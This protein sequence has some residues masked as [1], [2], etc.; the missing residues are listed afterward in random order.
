[1]KKI[2]VF[3]DS[4]SYPLPQS[5]LNVVAEADMTVFC[6]DGLSS[7]SDLMLNKNFYAVKGNC[8]FVAFDE[9]L[10]LE[11]EGVKIFITHGHKYSVKSSLLNLEY[12]AKEIGA[13]LVLFGHTHEPL[14]I[15]SDGITL[16]NSGSMSKNVFGERT[17]CYIVIA[18]KKI[19]SKI[20]KIS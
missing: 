8:D 13:D 12:K 3:S 16:I 7:L 20:V 6:G 11:V 5:F 19:I 4:H 10:T 18:D 2:V 17:Y 14:E 9:E 15:V 1:M